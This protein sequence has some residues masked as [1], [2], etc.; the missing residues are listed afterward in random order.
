MILQSNDDNNFTRQ[1]SEKI[2]LHTPLQKFEN[3]III[4]ANV[5]TSIFQNLVKFRYESVPLN[6]DLDY[7]VSLRVYPAD[8][9]NPVGAT[10]AVSDKIPRAV[11]LSYK[12]LQNAGPSFAEK[13]KTR[14][15]IAMPDPME[16][17]SKADLTDLFSTTGVTV[18]P[19]NMFG[20]TYQDIKP[21][22]SSWGSMPFFKIKPV[23]LQTTVVATS[24]YGGR[25]ATP[26]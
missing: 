7:F 4:M 15:V 8:E 21:A 22:L 14:F 5:D 3:K 11:I 23:L 9:N 6:E 26:A 1:Q 13:G 25:V 18:V 17:P 16:T 10:M 19:I 2:L 24:P 12:D 20:Q